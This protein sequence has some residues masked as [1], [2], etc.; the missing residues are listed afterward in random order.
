MCLKWEGGR[1]GKNACGHG[2]TCH[3]SL[4]SS[5]PTN[6][7]R[8]ALLR[9]LLRRSPP[10]LP[11]DAFLPQCDV[12]ALGPHPLLRLLLCV[13]APS[14]LALLAKAFQVHRYRSLEV[15]IRGRVRLLSCCDLI[16]LCPP[17]HAKQSPDIAFAED[18]GAQERLEGG[19][20]KEE[21]GYCPSREAICRVG[22]CGL[23]RECVDA[24]ASLCAEFLFPPS[25]KNQPPR[26]HIPTCMQALLAIV[27]PDLLPPSSSSASPAPPLL[28]PT[29]DG[30]RAVLLDFVA[31][32]MEGGLVG[33]TGWLWKEEDGEGEAA[34]DRRLL[35][36]VLRALCAPDALLRQGKE[37]CQVS[38][39]T[40]IP[41][42]MHLLHACI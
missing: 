22:V 18:D 17:T 1:R 15:G 32:A 19:D 40:C 35:L 8:A 23:P 38:C 36:A 27:T 25:Q 13:D 2:R 26:I 42:R 14:A 30:T 6:N 34:A 20:E 24:C 33:T 12:G 29:D 39:A 41:R 3:H 37:R 5:T 28:S 16:C 4:P 10:A 9:L 11:D 31:A 7:R 21:G